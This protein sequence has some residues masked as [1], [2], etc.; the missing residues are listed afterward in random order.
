MNLTLP[1]LI[2]LG[3]LDRDRVDLKSSVKFP[4]RWVA[5]VHY[6]SEYRISTHAD[7]EKASGSQGTK[8]IMRGTRTTLVE[9]FSHASR[10]YCR[11]AELKPQDGGRN[12]DRK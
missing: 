3:P 2:A 9:G 12:M 5:S 4:H 7:C 8:D 1:A 10:S 11:T 6:S